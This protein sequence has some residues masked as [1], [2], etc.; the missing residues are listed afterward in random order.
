M[1]DEVS[2]ALNSNLSPAAPSH[3]PIPQAEV[4]EAG[5]NPA[6]WRAWVHLVAIN[7]SLPAAA[8][9]ADCRADRVDHAKQAVTATQFL[10]SVEEKGCLQM[11]KTHFCI[12]QL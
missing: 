10:K 6:R 5:E 7:L 3:S 9:S 12:I 4:D 2:V 11:D 1:S 8:S